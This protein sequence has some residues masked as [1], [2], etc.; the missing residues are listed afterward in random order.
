MNRFEF[1]KEL[2]EALS[3]SV[4]AKVIAENEAFYRKYIEDE[5]QKGRSEAAIMEELGSP[6]LIANT[7]I[8]TTA[9]EAETEEYT[10]Y[11]EY[12][13][14]KQPEGTG[15]KVFHFSGW[16]LLLILIIIIVLVISLIAGIVSALPGVVVWI[17]I[18]VLLYK[19]F[20]R[21]NDVY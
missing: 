15:Q 7:I 11:M 18:G 2:R 12:S 14:D 19:W 13:E 6:R 8:D 17:I 10:E 16:W 3:G 4:S 20:R 21:K 1:I 9:P 5:L